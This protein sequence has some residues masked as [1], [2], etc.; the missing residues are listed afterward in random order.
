MN[1]KGPVTYEEDCL[2]HQQSD[3]CKLKDHE[4]HIMAI[5]TSVLLNVQQ[6]LWSAV[7]QESYHKS[8]H[9]SWVVTQSRIAPT[10]DN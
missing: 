4:M 6:L 3:K 9:I 2:L 8:P 10:E 5:L 7:R 1:V